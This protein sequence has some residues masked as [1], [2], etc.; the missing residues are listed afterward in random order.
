MSKTKRVLLTALALLSAAANAA[1][2]PD[3][4]T[5]SDGS[6]P[7]QFVGGPFNVPNLASD[8][9]YLGDPPDQPHEVLVCKRRARN[10]DRF[11]LA[12]A[13]S[14][15]LRAGVAKQK[16]VLRF[17]VE[18]HEQQPL[19]MVKPDFHL[20]LFDAQG[21]Q[22][23]RSSFGTEDA[24]EVHLELPLTSIPDGSYTAIVTGYNGLGATYSAEIG[25]GIAE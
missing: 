9:I 10:C 16:Q 2:Q 5:L 1:P 14:D 6:G 11:A 4:G 18:V 8:S 17:S 15:Q 25:V 7:L 3:S 22:L 12:V 21:N 19:P 23:G 13:L 24:E 20:Y